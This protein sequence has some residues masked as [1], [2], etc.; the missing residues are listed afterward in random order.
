M[1]SCA[2]ESIRPCPQLCSFRTLRLV[3]CVPLLLC[4][5]AAN[6]P[7]YLM[8]E[9]TSGNVCSDP[10]GDVVD[11]LNCQADELTTE[12]LQEEAEG[13]EEEADNDENQEAHPRQLTTA[14]LSRAA[15]ETAE[16]RLQWLEDNNCNAERRD[17][18]KRFP[19]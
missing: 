2:K 8:L 19:S 1:D 18:Q 3:S 16:Q 6:L 13:R 7:A 9:I 5:A 17:S 12:E 15:L 14:I 4:S 10:E 11:V